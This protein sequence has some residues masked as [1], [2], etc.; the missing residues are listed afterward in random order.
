MSVTRSDAMENRHAW[1]TFLSYCA[2]V[3]T[4]DADTLEISCELPFT[5]NAPHDG[6]DHL[7]CG[8]LTPD[9]NCVQLQGKTKQYQ[10]IKLMNTEWPGS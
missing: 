4:P 8:A 6:L 9:I 1:T 5:L 3:Q 7:W 10:K 2:P